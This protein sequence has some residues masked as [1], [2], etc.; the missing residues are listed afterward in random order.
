MRIG[1]PK[2]SALLA[3]L[4]LDV[5]RVVSVDR[6]VEELWSGDPPESATHAVQVYIS[7]LRKT[8]GEAVSR[9]GHGYLLAVAPDAVDVHRFARLA[10]QGHEEL[11]EGRVTDAVETLRA[12]LSLWRGPALADFS[13]ESF[14]QAEVVRLDEL[15]F[16]A[17]EDRID[18]DLGLGRSEEL[19]TEIQALVE[20]QPLRERPRALLMRALYLAGRQADALAAYRAA[21][22]TLVT[23]LGIEPG[24]E[25]RKLEAAILRQDE[26][27][28]PTAPPAASAIRTRRLAAV[29]SVAVEEADDVDLELQERELDE[30]A[31]A[32]A[33]AATRHG[34]V[35]EVLADGSVVAVFGVPV[36]HEDDPLRAARA[37]V[38]IREAIGAS[39]AAHFFAAIDVG[40]VAAS[41]HSFS[42]PPVRSAARLRLDAR[43]GEI[44]VS[45][46]AARR[47]DHAAYLT[48]QGDT[49][50]LTELATTASAFARRL[51][52]P[53]VG[54]ARH[55]AQLRDALRRAKRDGVVRGALI[56]GAPGIGKSRLAEE[57]T[58]RSRGVRVLRG[59]CL[60]YG[61]GITYWP[62]REMLGEDDSGPERRAVLQA[63]HADS[64]QPAA[65]IALRFRQLCE[66][67]ARAKPLVLVFDNLHS[68]EPTLLNLI[69]SLVARG[70]GPIL[71]VCLARD[72]LL[73]SHPDFLGSHPKVER[74]ALDALS[75]DETGELLQSLT[76][77]VLDS[78][79]H[80]ELIERAEGNPLFLE[81][82][83]SLALEGGLVERALPE[84]VQALLTA[85]V[86]NL[87]P[88][89]RALLERGAVTGRAFTAADA[90]AL[91][92]T[93]ALPTA[94]AHLQTLADRGFLLRG[95]D[96]RFSFRHA[97]LHE[98]VYRSVPKRLRADLHER[99]ADRLG[100]AH[101]GHT[102]LDKFVG[103]HLEQAHRLRTELGESGRHV[104]ALATDAGR[105]LGAAGYLAL[106]RGD[107]P[108]AAGLLGRATA[109]LPDGDERRHELLCEL[110]VALSS[111]GDWEAARRAFDDAIA[112]AERLGATRV[113]LRARMEAAYARLLAKPDGAAPE[114]LAIVESAIPKLE[115]FHDD[116]S[117]ARAWVL[118]GYVRGGIHGDHEAWKAAEERALLYY[119]RTAFPPATCMQQIAAATYWG[120]TPVSEGIER[121]EQLLADEALGHF[122]RA[123]VIPYVGGLHAQAGRFER[124]REL[125]AEAEDICAEVGASHS[126][127]IHCGTVRADIE[128]L[129]DDFLAAERVLREQC[130]LLERMRDRSHLAARAA[131]LA[132]ALVGLGNLDEAE[133]WADVSRA[134]AARDDRS[135]LLVLGPVEARVLAGSGSLDRAR[136]RAEEIVRLADRTDG[137]NQIAAARLALADVLRQG[138]LPGEARRATEEA[139]VLFERK[140]N[141]VG[142]TRARRLLGLVA[143]A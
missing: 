114:L 33:A 67:L 105:R 60:S 61:E 65:E 68:A 47:I 142:A 117:L 122:G 92:E 79:Q 137:L 18:A 108:A 136:E 58:R 101:A 10:H 8:F 1:G 74:I 100:E 96:D 23:Q 22:E 50:T 77:S 112:G 37:A 133:R 31:V 51:D 115:A 95:D 76:R 75:K 88:G 84:T 3:M 13:Y 66:S 43:A 4:A 103:Y 138:G 111:S 34:G 86:D 128:L 113:E 55:V 97:M 32:V 141:R 16:G 14:A 9:Q 109:L 121:C 12:A 45:T 126:A 123:T 106:K 129:A 134:N 62:L 5:G 140:E 81:Q 59:A 2:P 93:A 87:G 38:E 20:A 124:A 26:S 135:V 102:D 21:R 70:R 89:E 69:D 29:L 63:L 127:V 40:E 35:S 116:R 90:T 131:K 118:L 72:E 53:F 64:P 49:F 73:E 56:V 85:R 132:E 25:L 125:V 24:P 98:S 71:V 30:V 46:R 91:L 143:Q 119:R 36:V 104:E 17:L 99:S 41:E 39:T 110:G 44:V 82:L 28:L 6:L 57:F 78:N 120:P 54:R 19:V 48:M 130:A 83:V 27:L 7:Q 94:S 80:A 52:T 107:M 42:G 139:I 11:L 15:R